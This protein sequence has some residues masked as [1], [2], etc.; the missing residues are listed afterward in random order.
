MTEPHSIVDRTIAARVVARLAPYMNNGRVRRSRLERV[1]RSVTGDVLVRQQLEREVVGRMAT[2]GVAIEWDTDHVDLA[3]TS[4]TIPAPPAL[5]GG[6]AGLPTVKHDDV[7]AV[8]IGDDDRIEVDF[9]DA[10]ERARAF[11][12]LS[13]RLRRPDQHLLTAELEV[14]LALL[15]RGDGTPVSQDLPDDF[16]SFQRDG[17]EA[18][19]AF[20]ALVVHNTR[21]VWSIALRYMGQTEHLDV[22]DIAAYGNLGL[23]RAVQKFDA[24]MGNKFS[25]YATWWI[26]QAITRA[27]LDH[28]RTIRI[29]V[30]LGEKIARTRAARTRL[31]MR[32]IKPTPRRLATETGFSEKD[33]ALHL[34]LMQGIHSLD[35]PIGD[36]GATLR[37]YL[38][39]R[40]TDDDELGG[41]DRRLLRAE[42]EKSFAELAVRE[43]EVIR[44]RFGFIDGEKWTLED[45]GE[46]FG[47]T[48]ERIRQIEGKALTKLQHP[49]TNARLRYW[50]QA[51]DE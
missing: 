51:V 17:S 10:V 7:A 31:A 11:L 49:S 21:L 18:A 23:I 26:R 8:D 14:G 35:T 32:N 19:R 38:M 40:T 22:E 3:A 28:G 25:T 43:A 9:D 47:L 24:G 4:T 36:G 1:I 6:E 16:R 13:A 29:P 37:D 5:R 42:F 46:R 45:I 44:L 2:A 50:V 39:S 41:F 27:L 15:M 34:E 48:R 12:H 30:H 33:V 20:D